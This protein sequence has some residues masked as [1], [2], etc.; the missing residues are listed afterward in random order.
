VLANTNNL[1]NKEAG[2]LETMK[3]DMFDAINNIYRKAEPFK[4]ELT[5]DFI[6]TTVSQEV[7]VPDDFFVPKQVIFYNSDGQRYDSKELQY[8]E[9]MR[10]NPN[11]EVETSS[12]TELLTPVTPVV[13]IFTKENA[14]YDGLVGFTF[15]DTDPQQLLWKPAIAGTAKLY[16]SQSYSTAVGT[17]LTLSPALFKAYHDLIVINVTIKRIVRMLTSVPDDQQSKIYGLQTALKYYT[18]EQTIISKDLYGYV[19]TNS[20][21][22]TIEPFNF[23]NNYADMIL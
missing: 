15:S 7:D 21:T 8:E 20:E 18:N 10:W 9:Y 12:F 11:V 3:D 2:Y 6:L 19:N 4:T 1:G 16:Y 23:L 14:D 13:E 5:T 22:P 17:D